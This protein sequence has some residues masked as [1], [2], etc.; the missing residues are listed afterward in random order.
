MD[1]IALRCSSY[2]GGNARVFWAFV[3]TLECLE[4]NISDS[5][6]LPDAMNPNIRLPRLAVEAA[7]NKS[8]GGGCVCFRYLR[9]PPDTSGGGCMSTWRELRVLPPWVHGNW[10][11]S[12][13][14][15]TVS[16][17]I[18]WPDFCTPPSAHRRRKLA[19][20]RSLSH[21]WVNESSNR[22]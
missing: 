3:W 16:S 6:D 12:V 22:S 5:T 18:W 7:K 17:I 1:G 9:L 10:E 14:S 19:E 11:T 2:V 20:S 15:P 21:E 4:V 8:R 13:A